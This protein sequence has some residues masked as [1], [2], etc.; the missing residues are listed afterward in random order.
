MITKKANNKDNF[1]KQVIF[2]D[3]AREGWK[4]ILQSLKP[5]SRILL[6]S[7][8]GITDREGSGIFDPVLE[9]GLSYDFYDLNH[10]LSISY[11]ELEQCISKT[12]YDLILLVH[13]FG[14]KIQNIKAIIALC[15]KHN[16]IVKYDLKNKDL[17]LNDETL[18]F[19][20]T[21]LIKKL[22]SLGVEK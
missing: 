21:D 13:Y 15:K 1:R 16:L 17:S 10:D 3:A 5:N 22:D 9:T 14:F 11:Y 19:S 4:Y 12:K 20:V 7:Y 6:P 2:T 18:R 8:I